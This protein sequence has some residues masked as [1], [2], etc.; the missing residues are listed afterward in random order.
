M[1]CNFGQWILVAWNGKFNKKCSRHFMQ[2]LPP[3]TSPFSLFINRSMAITII[4]GFQSWSYRTAASSIVTWNLKPSQWIVTSFIPYTNSFIVACDIL[5]FKF[6]IS[7][8]LSEM[9]GH[10]PKILNNIRNSVNLSNCLFWRYI[11]CWTEKLLPLTRTFQNKLRKIS[12]HEFTA[13]Y[14]DRLS[15]H[16][17]PTLNV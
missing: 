7:D 9:F 1:C 10:Q 11:G 6:Q 12:V 4:D 17:K 13:V 2:I 16:F 8:S 5:I 15:A 3:S 14:F